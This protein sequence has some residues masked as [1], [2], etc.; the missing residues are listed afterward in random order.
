MPC[1]QQNGAGSPAQTEET[2]TEQQGGKRR[3]HGANRRDFIKAGGAALS[4]GIGLSRA[5]AAA[6][7]AVSLI[8]DPADPIAAGTPVTLA[9]SELRETLAA[10]NVGVAVRAA[11][12]QAPAQDIVIVVGG[13]NATLARNILERGNVRIAGATEALALMPATVEGRAILLASGADPRGLT[14]A[15][16]ELADRVRHGADAVAALAVSAPIVERPANKVRSIARCFESDLEDMGWFHDREIWREYLAMLARERFN[17]FSM[18]FG[19]QYNYPMEV[20]DVYLYFTYPFLLGVPGYDVRVRGLS[21]QERERNLATLRFIGEET[22]RRGLDFQVALWTHGYKFDSPRVNYRVEGITKENHA[23]YCRDAL[24]LLLAACPTISGLTFRIHGES[25]I[26][27][28]DYAFWQTVFEGVAQAGRRIEIDMHAKGMDQKTID[29][30]LATGMP[31]VVSPKYL[32]EHIGLPYHQASIRALEMPPPE[33]AANAHFALSNG[34]RKFLRYSYGDLFQEDR[35]HDV[36]FRIWPGTQRALM[37]GDPAFAAG[38]GRNASFCGAL[39]VELCEPLSFKGRMGSGE[40]GSRTAY[41]DA[42]LVPPRDWQKFSY[43]YRLW[44]RLTYNPDAA[45]DTWR[46][47][48]ATEYGAAAPSA[49]AALAHSTRIL[50]LVTLAHGPSASNNRYWPEIYT[51]MAIVSDDPPNPYND[52]TRPPRF[53]TAA[54]FDPQLFSRVDEFVEEAASGKLSARY[55]PL[56]VAAWLDGLAAQATAALAKARETAGESAARD[57]A[58]RRLDADVSITA[59]IGRFFAAKFR[60]AVLWQMFERSSDRDVAVAALTQYQ[61]ARAAFAEAAE[62]GRVYVDDVSYGPEPWL[63]GHWRDRLPAIGADIAAMRALIEKGGA[64]PVGSRPGP[65]ALLVAGVLKPP[66]R[67]QPTCAHTPAAHF[68]P[69]QPLSLWLNVAE[70]GD[71]TL[72]AQPHALLHYRHVNQA[73]AW[74]TADM[75]WQGESCFGAIPSAYTRSPY[76]LQYYFELRRADRRAL[77]PGLAPDLANQPYFVSRRAA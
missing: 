50:P 74:Q 31:V 62:A 30:A 2:V 73:E 57:P 64:V 9:L 48:L 44:G 11:I 36:L 52:T 28:G 56:E 7:P 17:R 55:S 72:V 16:T 15:V 68:E 6:A 12:A 18:T 21:D 33:G 5:G 63:R 40:R 53:T 14:Y 4:L 19:L 39:G 71:G 76:P 29:L 8:L 43:L 75:G 54:T 22:V 45:P 32:A 27:E 23:P 38:Y 47:T 24:K 10:R 42:T 58:L 66:A 51:N 77:W 37:W 67:W 60:S 69:G 65:A 1:W 41:A 61:A 20:S 3:A 13:A 59:A 35:R 70:A 25:G 46:R 34:A 49:E 26:P